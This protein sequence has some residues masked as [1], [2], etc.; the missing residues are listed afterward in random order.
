MFNAYLTVKMQEVP[1]PKTP[2]NI[3]L[4]HLPNSTSLCWL[5]L[6]KKFCPP[7][8]ILDPLFSTRTYD[9][10]VSSICVKNYWNVCSCKI[11][12]QKYNCFHVSQ[13][14][15]G[16]KWLCN[17]PQVMQLWHTRMTLKWIEVL[18]VVICLISHIGTEVE[19]TK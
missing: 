15:R 6:G 4:F 3:G 16:L 8:Q 1:G 17:A 5:N 13:V 11:K 10:T 18:S 7:D 12:R 14:S 19:G 2:A 9:E